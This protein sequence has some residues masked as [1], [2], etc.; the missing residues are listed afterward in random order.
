VDT[1]ACK[2]KNPK[3]PIC[4]VLMY[5][6]YAVRSKDTKIISE[7]LDC[8][9]DVNDVTN[10]STLDN[11]LTCSS[12]LKD[13]DTVRLLLQRGASTTHVNSEG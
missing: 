12:R 11:A 7:L 8:G 1:N 6:Q 9:I 5:V 2:S 10:Y 4:A 3:S 13:L